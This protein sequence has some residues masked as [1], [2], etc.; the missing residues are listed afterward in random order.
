M[1][2]IKPPPYVNPLPPINS[3]RMYI[4]IKSLHYEK[5]SKFIMF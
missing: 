2:D 1:E 5:C 3:N 4:F